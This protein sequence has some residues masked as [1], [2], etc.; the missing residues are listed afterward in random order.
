MKRFFFLL[1]REND[2]HD[3]YLFVGAW[4]IMYGWKMEKEYRKI[5]RKKKKEGFV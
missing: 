1:E 2:C 3:Y 4:C 5:K